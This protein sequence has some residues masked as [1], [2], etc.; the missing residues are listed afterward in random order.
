MRN[1]IGLAFFLL[2]IGILD[3]YFFEVVRYFFRKTDPNRVRQVYWLVTGLVYLLVFLP[4]M[5]NRSDLPAWFRNYIAG[6]I[7]ILYLF[8]LFTIP[9]LLLDDLRRLGYWGGLKLNLVSP[10]TAENG[11]N[12][13][14]F[15]R[16]LGIFIA[17]IPAL[18]LVGGIIWGAYR[19]TI[20]RVQIQ[21]EAIPRA[22]EGLKIIQLS[23]IHTGSFQNK[24]AVNRGID[25][26]LAEKPDL[27]VFTGDL[28]NNQS[29]EVL[30]WISSF[31]RL[32]APL[33]VY[34]I[35]G[36]HDYGDYHRWD[37]V[38]DK[39]ANMDLMYEAHRKMGWRLLLNEHESISYKEA[40]FNLI[41]V[42]NW[43]KRGFARYGKLDQAMK[44]VSNDFNILLSHDPSHW[45]GEIR[46]KYKNIQ[47]TLSGHTHGMQFGVEI[48]GWIKWSPVK[49]VYKQWAGLYQEDKQYLYV[50]RGFGFIGYPGRVGILPEITVLEFKS[51]V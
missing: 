27:I 34:S 17:A 47:L 32:K 49:W 29:K 51:K 9:F 40:K 12:R 2:V 35:L 7:F 24:E 11:L 37:T 31:S 25:L 28:V 26:V 44:G 22:L 30:P 36:N 3:W 18:S 19:Y 10:E 8:K 6:P 1:W 48:P 20:R 4:V 15:L 38:E 41:G 33:G 45:D 39:Q 16:Q 5:I 42:E 43:G 46:K 50:N 14:A 21:H 13:S 23:D